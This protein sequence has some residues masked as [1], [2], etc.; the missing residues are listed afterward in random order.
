MD[1]HAIYNTRLPSGHPEGMLEAFA[2]IYRNFAL[3]LS[4]RIEGREATA[5]MRDFPTVEDG[6]RGMRFIDAVV[7]SSASEE[8]WTKID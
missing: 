1:S 8:K 6:V 3:T 7:A 5:E 2:N 4:A